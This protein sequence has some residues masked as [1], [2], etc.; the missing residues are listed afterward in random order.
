MIGAAILT[1]FLVLA[2]G[3]LFSWLF[4]SLIAGFYM[5]IAT[6][7]ALIVTYCAPD[8]VQEDEAAGADGG[9]DETLPVSDL[10]QKA[11]DELRTL[12]EKDLPMLLTLMERLK[13]Q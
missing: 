10:R 1:F 2:V 11:L 4:S 9:P 8:R 12:P 6:A 5:A 3:I 13:G 7:S